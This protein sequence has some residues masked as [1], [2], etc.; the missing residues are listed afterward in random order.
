LDTW[1]LDPSE[2]EAYLAREAAA[3]DYPRADEVLAWYRTVKAD[4]CFCFFVFAPVRALPFVFFA[5]VAAYGETQLQWIADTLNKSTA[6]WLFLF[7]HYPVYS[8]GS[9]GNTQ[10]L[11]TVR[12]FR[13]LC[14]FFLFDLLTFCFSE[15]L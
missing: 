11:I 7:G 9:N 3:K 2:S 10:E 1:A 5:Q 12:L 14:L 8:G 6:D 15:F 13:L 4:V